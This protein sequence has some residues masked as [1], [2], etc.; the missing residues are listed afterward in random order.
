[1]GPWVDGLI[2]AGSDRD[3]LRRVVEAFR[4][5]GGSSK[6]VMLQSA[7]CYAPTMEQ[8]L[9]D[10]HDQ[11]RHALLDASLILNLNLPSDFDH[12]SRFTPPERLVE[13]LRIS[14]D[15]R[16]F[17]DWLAQDIELGFDTIYLHH[18]GRDLERFIDVFSD[19]V[20]PRITSG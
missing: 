20:L 8:A 3:A 1:M 17:T 13:G 6:P 11:W 4:A 19:R 9:A 16:Q 7:I 12:A 14:S 2:T 15:T 10:A 5:G 18:V